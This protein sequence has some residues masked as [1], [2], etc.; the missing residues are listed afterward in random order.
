MLKYT[1]GRSLKCTNIWALERSGFRGPLQ[2]L[3]ISAAD[4]CFRIITDINTLKSTNSLF[5]NTT[6]NVSESF[7]NQG[8]CHSSY[9]LLRLQ[10]AGQVL[11][12]Q[13]VFVVAVGD[14]EEVQISARGHHLVEG[15][16]L[17]EA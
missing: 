10:E 9:L 6:G 11:K 14:H 8:L 3:L 13:V 2:P 17:L 1:W 16:E 15:A 12:V 4:T 5:S 7:L